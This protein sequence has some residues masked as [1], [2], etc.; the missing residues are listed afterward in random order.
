MLRARLKLP[1]GSVPRSLICPSC[2]RTARL[3]WSDCETPTMSP[4]LLIASAMLIWPPD[5]VPSE[6][7]LA[8]APH[9]RCPG[10]VEDPADTDDLTFVVDVLVRAELGVA[11]HAEIAHLPLLHKKAWVDPSARTESP[12]TSPWTLI[13]KSLARLPP[14]VPVRGA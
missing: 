5:S 10:A 7:E 8:S 1:P 11:E 4:A 13:R 12:T 6:R 3:P 2:Q 9:H 14:S